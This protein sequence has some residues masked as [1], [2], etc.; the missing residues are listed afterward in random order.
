MH[1]WQYGRVPQLLT[2][3]ANLLGCAMRTVHARSK[4][5]SRCLSTVSPLELSEFDAKNS[6][7]LFARGALPGA[8]I[9]LIAGQFHWLVFH[10][11][12]PGTILTGP[13]WLGARL[14]RHRSNSTF[15]RQ[16]Q[17][18]LENHILSFRVY[19]ALNALESFSCAI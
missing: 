7:A 1:L 14:Q 18:L 4:S 16:V 11:D 9:S 3:T 15:H 19:Q 13:F 6:E 17:S 10:V 12:R 5:I 2:E 8:C